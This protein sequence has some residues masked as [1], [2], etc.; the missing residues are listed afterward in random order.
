VKQPNWTT[1]SIKRKFHLG[2][3]TAWLFTQWAEKQQAS[4]KALQVLRGQAGGEI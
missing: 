3:Q 1:P 4:A 2:N